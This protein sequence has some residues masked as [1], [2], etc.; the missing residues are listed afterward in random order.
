[1]A[2]SVHAATTIE[3][4]GIPASVII[5]EPF[6]PLARLHARRD[7]YNTLPI[8]IDPSVQSRLSANQVH[9]TVNN[10]V[11]SLAAALFESRED[12]QTSD[13]AKPGTPYIELESEDAFEA[14]A[15]ERGWVMVY[16]CACKC[17]NES[18]RSS[19]ART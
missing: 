15:Y 8:V 5:A 10:L 17:R 9:Q 18:K 16:P 12:A 2:W 11:A 4:I 14:P 13:V 7:G 6:A 19:E 3:T 1:M